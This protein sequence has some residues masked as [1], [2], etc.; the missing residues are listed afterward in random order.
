[1]KLLFVVFH[2]RPLRK[3]HTNA[4][5]NKNGSIIEV[6]TNYYILIYQLHAC[7]NYYEEKK[8]EEEESSYRHLTGYLSFLGA[9]LF[10]EHIFK[11]NYI[12]LKHIKLELLLSKSY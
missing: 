5:M 12:L 7:E 6:D 8:K 1:M 3:Q 11:Q 10:L 2:G 9:S 4:K